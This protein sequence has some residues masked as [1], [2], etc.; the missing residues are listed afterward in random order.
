MTTITPAVSAPLHDE[1]APILRRLSTLDRLEVPV[2]AGLV[3]VSGP[4][5]GRCGL[6]GARDQ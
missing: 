5:V 6:Q 2:L 3:Y 4:G 1:D